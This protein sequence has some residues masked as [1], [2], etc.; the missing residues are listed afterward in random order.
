[1]KK[2]I[3]LLI[4]ISI[5]L[6]LISVS[7][8]ETNNTLV[9]GD[10][11]YTLSVDGT[12]VIIKYNGKQTNLI[13]PSVLDGHPVKSI[14]KSAFLRST[15][16]AVIIEDGIEIIGDNAFERCSELTR[17]VIPES[18]K[19]IGNYAFYSCDKL[20]AEVTDTDI[21]LGNS[22]VLDADI[23]KQRGRVESAEMQLQRWIDGGKKSEENIEKQRNKVQREKEK[24]A[25][26]EAQL[27]EAPDTGFIIPAGT[28][29]LPDKLEQIGDYAFSACV[30]LKRIVIPESV[31][32]VG[33]APFALCTNL[34]IIVSPNHPSLAMKDGVLYS[35]PDKRVISVPLGTNEY[36]IPQGIQIIDDYAFTRLHN[37]QIIIPDSVTI[38]GEYAFVLCD[39][40]TFVDLGN[41]VTTIGAHAFSSCD[42][43][44][45]MT[46]PESV[47][48]I[49]EGAFPKNIVLM[50][51]PD[52]A[53]EK[54]CKEN[55]I[56]YQY[57]E[58]DMSWLNY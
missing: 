7:Y 15:I 21:N 12:A 37:T 46:I 56:Q 55:K 24:L 39:N 27:A 9:C 58:S 47:T 53:A 42:R 16:N 13:I 33:K 30:G 36:E 10:F 5:I 41:G 2:A 50:I 4:C 38:I 6:G 25:A 49:G 54:Y 22:S 31:I 17:I 26:L 44:K 52:S 20:T 23:E 35:K 40:L 34:S 57:A 18:V 8:A 19:V 11:E 48:S 28:G 32:S 29:L 45:E 14:G 51:S 1:M 43:L 3:S